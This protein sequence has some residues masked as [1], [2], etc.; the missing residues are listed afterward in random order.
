[1]TEEERQRGLAVLQKIDAL[2]EQIATRQG[3][4]VLPTSVELIRKMREERSCQLAK[5]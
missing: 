5:L 1:M 3:D 4:A 2:Q